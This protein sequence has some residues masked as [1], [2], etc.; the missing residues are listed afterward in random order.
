MSNVSDLILTLRS[1]RVNKFILFNVLCYI[2][3][4]SNFRDLNYK[5]FFVS[6]FRQAQV[7]SHQGRTTVTRWVQEVHEIGGLLL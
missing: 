5:F 7:L 3:V 1:D 2:V 6:F 4:V